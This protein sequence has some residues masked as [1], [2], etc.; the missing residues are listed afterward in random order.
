MFC[1]ATDSAALNGGRQELH[2]RIASIPGLV[3]TD[4]GMEG[5]PLIPLT[6]LAETAH[7]DAFQGALDWMIDQV[8][9]IDV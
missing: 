9:Q 6:S 8:R 7:R 1:E 2:D 5:L 4:A 3:L